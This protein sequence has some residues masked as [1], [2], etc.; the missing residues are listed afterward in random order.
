MTHEEKSREP[1]ERSTNHTSRGLVIC[2]AVLAV[3]VLSPVPLVWCLHKTGTFEIASP[4]FSAVYA[5]LEYL[6][7]HIEFVKHFYNWQWRFFQL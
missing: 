5:P 4:V 1:A 2:V 3:Y 7:E 6:Y